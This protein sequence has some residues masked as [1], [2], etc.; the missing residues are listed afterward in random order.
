MRSNC[1]VL[2]LVVLLLA[3]PLFAQDASNSPSPEEA[4]A[5]EAITEMMPKTRQGGDN[6]TDA[7]L[8]VQRE[9]GVEMAKRARQFL[10]EYPASKKAD[11]A[12]ALVNMGLGGASVAGDTNA[13]EELKN[14]T[15]DFIKD[16]KIPDQVKLHTFA[17]NYLTQ[18]AIK[19]GKHT[20]DSAPDFQKAS[21]EAL[22]A[23]ADALPNKDD[24]FKMLLLQ[25]K[26]DRRSSA[27]DGKAIAQR[28]LKHPGAS[29]AIKA[30]AQRLVSGEK[31][32]EI[33]K[34]LDISFTA[35]DGRKVDLKEMK[36]KVVLID[37][38][39]TW[40]GP[41][42][43]EMPSVKKTYEA[44][45]DKGFEIVG[46]SLDDDKDALNNYIKKNAIAWPQYFDGKQ[47]NNEISFRYGID[48]VPTEWLVDKQG[49]LRETS[50]RGHLDASVDA[51]LN[52]KQ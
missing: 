40:C 48:G 39:A 19:N 4:K 41:C 46:I 50:A 7:D 22:F 6:P 20:M 8:K 9:A 36:G 47:W 1:L 37:F 2:P 38:W 27:E 16:P 5:F 42:V 10:K 21:M 29:A 52:E 11:D 33:G 45:H 44:F 3:A 13:A 15:A 14:R 24:I 28:V 23:A 32:Y 49:N 26:S 34:P 17:I 30:E 25:A 18:W 12:Q 35:V 43:A 31:A 51:L